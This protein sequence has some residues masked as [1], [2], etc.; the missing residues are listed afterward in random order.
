[1]VHT[2]SLY[3]TIDLPSLAA[4]LSA[5]PLVFHRW[6]LLLSFFMF[7][8]DNPTHPPYAYP[9]KN[10]SLSWATLQDSISY[11]MIRVS[12]SGL[13]I[14]GHLY[15]VERPLYFSSSLNYL[16]IIGT[17]SLSIKVVVWIELD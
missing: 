12:T 13:R 15:M 11:S 17:D 14:V 10:I 2:I 5:L 6:L 9:S 4:T 8:L 3:I 7:V 1:M 16:S